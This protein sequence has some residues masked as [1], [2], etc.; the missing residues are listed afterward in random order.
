MYCKLAKLYHV[1]CYSAGISLKYAKKIKI[2]IRKGKEVWDERSKKIEV[3][4]PAFDLISKKFVKEVVSEFGVLPYK[5]FIK[6]AKQN[7]KKFS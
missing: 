2:E 1:P 6:K 5:N 3:F 7:L 4:N